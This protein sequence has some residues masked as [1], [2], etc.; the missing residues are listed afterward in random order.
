MNLKHKL[1]LA[2]IHREGGY[3]NHKADRGGAT[4]YGITLATAMKYGYIGDM[5]QFPME[6]AY[7]IYATEYW[8]A[9]ALDEMLPISEK[10]TEE[11]FDTGVNMGP[12]VAGTFLQR[13][14]NVLNV[15]ENTYDN[16]L[17]DGVVGNRTLSALGDYLLERGEEGEKVL[18]KMLN[19]LQGARYIKIAEANTTQELFVYGWFRTRIG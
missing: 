12:P 18:F 8:D 19:S 2:L 4:N 16:L 5:K 15:D 3:V 9:N 10:I 11:V 13:S 17:V 7:N 14:L 1:I 6:K